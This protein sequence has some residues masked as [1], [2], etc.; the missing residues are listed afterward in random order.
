MKYICHG[1]QDS[2]MFESSNADDCGHPRQCPHGFDSYKCMWVIM[3]D[4]GRKPGEYIP[5]FLDYIKRF[6]NNDS[7]RCLCGELIDSDDPDEI[8]CIDCKVSSAEMRVEQ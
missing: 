6:T 3:D 1:C 4:S 5:E 2:C 7:P 8:W